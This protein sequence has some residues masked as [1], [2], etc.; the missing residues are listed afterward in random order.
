MYSM[1][2]LHI[3]YLNSFDDDSVPRYNSN[4]SGGRGRGQT[5]RCDIETVPKRR[6]I[7]TLCRNGAISRR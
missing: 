7:E 6:D 2:S 5:T 1:Y 4:I 3:L